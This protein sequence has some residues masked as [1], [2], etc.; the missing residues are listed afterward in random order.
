MSTVIGTFMFGLVIQLTGNMRISILVLVLV[1]GAS[2]FFLRP[3]LKSP[4]AKAIW[5]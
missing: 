2:L 4:I 5:G 3:L 1:F